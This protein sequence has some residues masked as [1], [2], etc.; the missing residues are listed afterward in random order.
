[1]STPVLVIAGIISL[2][3]ALAWI[4]FLLWAAIEDGAEQRRAY[5]VPE[6][7]KPADHQ[8][9]LDGS[10]ITDFNA[11]LLVAE[12]IATAAT[13]RSILS[14]ACPA[15]S[16]PATGVC[17]SPV[18]SATSCSNGCRGRS[19]EDSS[20]FGTPSKPTEMCRPSQV[21]TRAT[22]PGE[23]RRTVLCPAL[24]FAAD[25]PL[26]RGASSTAAP[27]RRRAAYVSCGIPTNCDAKHRA[28]EGFN[29]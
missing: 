13:K 15:R 8:I 16:E 19:R 29:A 27:S 23:S 3:S 17:P 5:K 25:L 10:D 26:W 20:S 22:E 12:V 11:R 24:S 14:S 18:R 1:M 21:A 6:A 7:A 28:E 9:R 2:V 4:G